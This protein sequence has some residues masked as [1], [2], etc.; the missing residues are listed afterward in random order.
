M[1]KSRITNITAKLPKG[2]AFQIIGIKKPQRPQREAELKA[3]IQKWVRQLKRRG[4]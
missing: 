1:M 3:E 4:H 2:S